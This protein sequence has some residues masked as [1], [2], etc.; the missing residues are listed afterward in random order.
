M[1]DRVP[2]DPSYGELQALRSML[3][4]ASEQRREALQERDAQHR[5]EIERLVGAIIDVLDST[6]RLL[7]RDETSVASWGLITRQFASAL[8]GTGL[9][10]IGSVGEMADP[11][12]HRVV[13]TCQ[14]T[15]AADAEVLTVLRR[16]YRYRG[17]VLRP[18][19]VIVAT[20]P[21]T[22][23]RNPAAACNSGAGEAST[24]QEQ[25]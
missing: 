2:A 9:D 6:D 1:S 8:N 10:V 7:R 23:V 4:D 20:N 3:F 19:E 14:T 18:A 5:E 22:S 16:G 13:E 15:K 21:H 17:R 12:T 24:D 11:R 25:G